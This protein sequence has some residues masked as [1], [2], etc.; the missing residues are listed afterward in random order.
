MN[1][2]SIEFHIYHKVASQKIQ[3]LLIQIQTGIHLV[4]KILHIILRKPNFSSDL[5][6]CKGFQLLN[7]LTGIL[8]IAT[9]VLVI[10]FNAFNFN[11]SFHKICIN[12][13]IEVLKC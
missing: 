4:S 5:K 6:L 10:T 2:K 13:A 1:N 12:L 11:L 8:F 7:Q 9:M 3:I